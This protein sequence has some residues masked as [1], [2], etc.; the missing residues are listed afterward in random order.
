MKMSGEPKQGLLTSSWISKTH[1]SPWVPRRIRPSCDRSALGSE[2][3]RL[4]APGYEPGGPRPHGILAPVHGPQV[5]STGAGGA[6][7]SELALDGAEGR[8]SASTKMSGESP[9]N[10]FCLRSRYVYRSL[11]RR[12]HHRMGA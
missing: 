4:D 9:K 2:S 1:G 3:T 12:H 5:R 11:F 7:R 8:G 10:P 6:E